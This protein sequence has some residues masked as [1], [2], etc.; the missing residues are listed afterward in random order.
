MC[1]KGETQT[2]MVMFVM[3]RLVEDVVSES[4]KSLETKLVNY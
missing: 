4:S 3:L 2:E 1:S